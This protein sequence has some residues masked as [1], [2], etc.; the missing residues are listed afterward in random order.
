MLG[1][2]ELVAKLEGVTK[3]TGDVCVFRLKLAEP[4]PFQPGQFV[5]VSLPNHQDANGRKISKA[6]SIASAQNGILELCIVMY[7]GGAL[8]PFLFAKNIGDEVIITGPYGMFTM[9][10]PVVPGTVFIGGGTGLAPLMSM[11]R[12]LYNEGYAE[13]LWLFYSMGSPQLFLFREE[14]L[15]FSAKKNLQLIASTSIADGIWN[16]EKGRVTDTFPRFLPQLKQDGIPNAS[17]QFYIC[18]PPLLVTD[19]VRMLEELGFRKENIHME[20]W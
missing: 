19:T 18:G 2:K 8:S 17:R 12:S 9:R 13:K 6:Y 20:K 7:P 14:L 4:F 10:K 16:F 3:Y 5:M 15:S 1:I 11:L